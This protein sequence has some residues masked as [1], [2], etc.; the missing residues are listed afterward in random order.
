VAQTSS[1]SSL[2]L[3]N[4]IS[5][6]T[7]TFKY[8]FSLYLT[9]NSTLDGLFYDYDVHLDHAFE[10][11]FRFPGANAKNIKTKQVSDGSQVSGCLLKHRSVFEM[12][13][14][15]HSTSTI[16]FPASA[17]AEQQKTLHISTIWE[18]RSPRVSACRPCKTPRQQ[19]T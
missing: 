13:N 2:S 19:A 3:H 6:L 5:V 10:R 8:P 14:A 4:G 16:P 11:A 7:D 12:L 18:I 17:L 9:Y 15:P 1:G